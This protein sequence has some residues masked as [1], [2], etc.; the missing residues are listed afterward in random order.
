MSAVFIGAY[1]P[2]PVDGR[3]SFYHKAMVNKYSDG[4]EILVSYTTPVAKKNPDGT[5]KRLYGGWSQTTGRHIKAFCGMS[6]SEFMAL[7]YNVTPAE[8]AMAYSGTLYR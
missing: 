3:K 2:L 6:K 7:P 8:K 4:S 5:I 1:E